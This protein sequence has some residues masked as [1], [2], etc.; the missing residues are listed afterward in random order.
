MCRL[1]K[2]SRSSYYSKLHGPEGKRARKCKELDQKIREVYFAAQGRNGSPWLAKDVHVRYASLEVHGSQTHEEDGARSKLS[3]LFKVTTDSSHY[4]KV[5]LNL[6]NRDFHREEP[7]ITCVS[8]LTYVPVVD[9]FI[10]LTVV[11]DLFDRKPIGWSIIN[12]M[13]ASQT[14]IPSIMIA[15]RNRKF[16][17]EIIF[18]SDRGVQYAC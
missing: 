10:Y 7:A 6:L 13:S 11:L 16:T 3:K 5:A 17:K 14:V 1:L 15:C 4:Y 2:V 18:H 8:D 9:G 12:G